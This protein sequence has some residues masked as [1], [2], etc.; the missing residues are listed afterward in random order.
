MRSNAL[1]VVVLVVALA[2]GCSSVQPDAGPPRTMLL[3]NITHDG[4]SWVA[5]VYCGI[6]ITALE[7]HPDCPC[8]KRKPILPKY[9]E[10]EAAE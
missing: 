4:H 7:H 1:L 10:A 5:A 2:S 3:E 8:G 6:Q 9:H